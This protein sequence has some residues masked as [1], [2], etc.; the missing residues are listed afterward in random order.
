MGWSFYAYFIKASFHV[1]SL[2][3]FFSRLS[4]NAFWIFSIEDLRY[5]NWLKNPAKLSRTFSRTHFASH[6]PS[7]AWE[8]SRKL[9][10]PLSINPDLFFEY[11]LQITLHRVLEHFQKRVEPLPNHSDVSHHVRSWRNSQKR[12]KPISTQTHRIKTR[13]KSLFQTLLCVCCKN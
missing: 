3:D 1:V 10:V 8:V 12:L 6:T 5:E 7:Y 2:I 9:Q 11:L 13:E 4:Q